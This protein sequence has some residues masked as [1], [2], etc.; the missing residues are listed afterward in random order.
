MKLRGPDTSIPPAD[1]GRLEGAD[2]RLLKHNV[3]LKLLVFGRFH[4]FTPTFS[5]AWEIRGQR[6]L[7]EAGLETFAGQP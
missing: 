6:N 2:V 4:I 3:P 7:P 5:P 1:L